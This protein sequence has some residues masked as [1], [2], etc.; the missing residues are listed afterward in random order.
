MYPLRLQ[1][2]PVPLLLLDNSKL[3]SSSL[4]SLIPG[5][6]NTTSHAAALWT[7]SSFSRPSG[8]ASSAIVQLRHYPCGAGRKDYFTFLAGYMPVYT[9]QRDV[10]FFYGNATVLTHSSL[11]HPAT[12]TARC[13]DVPPTQPSLSTHLH[14]QIVLPP[15]T[16]ATGNSL[17]NIITL[18][19]S[20]G[21]SERVLNFVH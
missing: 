18:N 14:G 9:N 10:C 15:P 1:P 11:W 17:L 7:R 3:N 20:W 8:N 13:L 6:R 19:E 2:G 5:L 4:P 16:A 12:S 21:T